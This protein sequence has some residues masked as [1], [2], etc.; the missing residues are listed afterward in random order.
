AVNTENITDATIATADI[1]LDAIDNTLVADDAINTENIADGQVQTTDIANLNVTTGKLAADAVTNAQL[2]DDAVNTE[3]IADGQVQT[4]DIANLNVTTGKLAADAV[5]NAQLADD[6]VNTENIADGQVQTTDIANLNVTTGKLAADAVTNAQLADDAVNT[7]NITDGTI[8]NSDIN[9]AAAIAGTKISPN[10]GSQNISTSGTLGAGATTVT[11]L[12]VSS[13]GDGSVSII[14]GD[15]TVTS[16]DR[17]LKE[18]IALLQNTLTKLDGLGGYNYNY[19]ADTDKKKQIGVIAQ[20]LEKVFPELVVVDERGYKMVNY[21]GL[22]PVLIQAIKEQQ[23]E[24]SSLN[25]KVATQEARLSELDA[26][27]KEMKSDLDLIKKMLMGDKTAKS[28]DK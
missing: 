1:A 6:A 28:E 10:F 23:L 26:D 14:N 3:N 5:T 22:I 25:Q 21:Q 7:E 24:I 15:G 11:S 17:R 12:K 27:N 8:A 16:S 9:A 19:K 2:A 13:L 18:N 20:E 4:T